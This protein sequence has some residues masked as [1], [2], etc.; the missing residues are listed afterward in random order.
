M[1]LLAI[2]ALA[3]AVAP[4]TAGAKAKAP[5]AAAEIISHVKTSAGGEVATVKA[6]YVCPEGNHLWVSAKQ[7]ETGK[8]DPALEGEGSSGISAAWLQNH[9][10]QSEFTCDGKWHTGTFQIHNDI[11]DDFGFGGFGALRRGVAYVQFCLIGETTFL[12]RNEW[13]KV[14]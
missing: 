13:V 5:A 14:N 1:L 10:D 7:T 12:S 6:R 3:I 2:A 11:E 9:P 8:R 4:A